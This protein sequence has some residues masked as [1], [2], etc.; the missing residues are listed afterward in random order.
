MEIQQ[1]KILTEHQK[2]LG[3]S[4]SDR[5]YEISSPAFHFFPSFLLYIFLF[6]CSV[7]SALL[8]FFRVLERKREQ[9]EW[10]SR[11]R[12]CPSE[13]DPF[14]DISDRGNEEGTMVLEVGGHLELVFVVDT[15]CPPSLSLS[16][17]EPQ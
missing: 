10:S 4:S 3:M 2:A 1:R 7:S 8:L 11:W 13:G 16:L 14:T 6:L 9:T 17:S 12:W 15:L 5:Y